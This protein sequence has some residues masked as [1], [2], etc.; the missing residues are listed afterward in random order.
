MGRLIALSGLLLLSGCQQE[1]ADQIAPPATEYEGRTLSQW[2]TQLAESETAE[3][4]VEAAGVLGEMGPAG[5]PALLEALRD[6]SEFVRAASALALADIGPE[7]EVAIPAIR[8]TLVD[9]SNRVRS[10]GQSALGRLQAAYRIAPPDLLAVDLVSEPPPG[11]QSIAGE[12]LV[13]PDGTVTLGQFGSVRV[14]SMTI[15]Q[16]KQS[17][18]RHLSAFFESPTVAV[19][20]RSFNS[21]VFYVVFESDELGDTVYRFPFTGTETLLDVIAYAQA[22]SLEEMNIWVAAPSPF[23]PSQGVILPWDGIAGE[24]NFQIYPGD[25]VVVSRQAYPKNEQREAKPATDDGEA[26]SRELSMQCL[27]AYRISPPDILSIDLVSE[28][29]VG[30]HLA[31][32]YLVNPDGTVTLDQYGG[33]KVASLTVAEAKQAIE[34]HLSKQFDSPIVS[35]SVRAYNSLVYY[36]VVEGDGPQ[37]S[38]YR[39]PVTGSD[40]VL[41]AIAHSQIPVFGETVQVIRSGNEILTAN[42]R[43]ITRLAATATNCQLLPDDRVVIKADG[44]TQ[45]AAPP[46]VPV[47]E[48]EEIP[49][50]PGFIVMARPDIATLMEAMPDESTPLE[51]RAALAGGDDDSRRASSEECI[52]L[53][54]L[55][56]GAE[57]EIGGQKLP[58]ASRIS[59]GPLEPDRVYIRSLEVDFDDGGRTE[60]KLFLQA[61]EVLNVPIRPPNAEN[62][63]LVLQSGH[64]DAVWSVTFSPDGKY[65]FTSSTSQGPIIWETATGRQVRSFESYKPTF[66]VVCN[67]SGDSFLANHA[68][69]AIL[70]DFITWEEK[71][72]WPLTWDYLMRP[73]SLAFSHD[74][75]QAIAA[76]GNFTLELDFADGVTD[77][78]FHED[79]SEV[80]CVAFS[81][82]GRQIFVG[83]KD[84][85]YL[86]DYFKTP[87]GG[88]VAMRA[89]SVG[90]TSRCAAFSPEGDVIVAESGKGTVGLWSADTGQ[91][92]R[93]L[94]GHTD[95]VSSVVFSPD[96]QKVLTGSSDKT[97]VVWEAATGRQLVVIDGHT[98]L[99]NS[100]A[101]SPDGRHV[102]TGSADNTAVL[103]DASS[104]ESVRDFSGRSERVEEIAF[105]TDGRRL[106]VSLHSN[107]ILWD[108]A[109][110]GSYQSFPAVSTTCPATMSPEGRKILT[111]SESGV[112][113]RDIDS[114]KQIASIAEDVDCARFS[115]DGRMLLTSQWAGEIRLWDA[116]TGAKLR[117]FVGQEGFVSSIA[118]SPNGK[119]V[120]TGSYLKEVIRWD[121]TTGEKLW[122]QPHGV[123]SVAFSPD[124]SKFATAFDVG[125][126]I[127][128]VWDAAT[129]EPLRTL[130]G[131]ELYGSHLAFTPDGR[132]LL[133]SE[134]YYAVLH[135]IAL[136]SPLRTFKGHTNWLLDACF[137]P[138]GKFLCTGSVDGTMRL[139]DVATGDEILRLISD[140]GEDWIAVTPEGLF[141]GSRQGRESVF[142]RAEEGLRVTPVDC[143]F[144][145]FYYPG[146]M[147]EIWR[148]QRPMPAKSL[149]GSPAP[150][151]QILLRDT[152]KR[153]DGRV[154]IDVVLTDQGGGIQDPWLFHNGSRAGRPLKV[155]KDDKTFRCEFDVSMVEGENRISVHSASRDGSWE[156]E[157]AVLTLD[158]D[159]SLPEPDLY[160]MAIGVDEFQSGDNL[161]G[162][163][164]GAKSI[165][166]LFQKHHASQYR[167]VRVGGLYGE[168]ATRQRILDYLQVLAEKAQPQDTIVV[169]LASHGLTIGQRYYLFPQDYQKSEGQTVN[170]AVWLWGMPID[171]LGNALSQVP[172]LKRV[173]IFD[174]CQSGG[175]VSSERSPFEFRGAVERFS[176]SQGIFCLAASSEYA[177][178]YEHPQTA[179]LGI[180]T[181]T[182]LAGMGAIEDENGLLGGDRLTGDGPDGEVDV[183]DWFRFADRHIPR[184]YEKLTSRKGHHV[185]M[186]GQE[187]SFAI[188]RL[189]P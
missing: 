154:T 48:H 114:G 97:A 100:V 65:V 4:R 181:F 91:Q 158:F 95:W 153:D 150:E 93:S 131:D 54:G 178:A 72:S 89:W 161:K 32:E 102:L 7:A 103:W 112:V 98:D 60:R 128:V 9:Q 175:A 144:R 25:R 85:G 45:V 21:Q 75:R 17:I 52:L 82:N 92:I 27:P 90:S 24:N 151:V 116:I 23:N 58:S 123:R 12:H 140:K 15:A 96:G 62:P 115:P 125:K 77:P 68:G 164:R 1:A 6:E 168:K 79:E 49:E 83:T 35:V 86:C 104:G 176:R 16:A 139:W 11:M 101:F 22:G 120:I 145:D 165:V 55:P 88:A 47:P 184:L 59:I 108:F 110:G 28:P 170:Q 19:S 18:E 51:A 113:I 2:A 30:T 14:A 10:A 177:Y 167:N 105:S 186:R 46:H 29:P 130:D 141:D 136:G 64:T 3:S 143:A 127:V 124:G 147:S 106:F 31:G 133:L 80:M 26:I 63:N 118:F 182:L 56:P 172:A 171:E 78:I 163:V 173:L 94:E 187:P 121:V 188:L 8:E 149:A 157:P 129:N 119:S 146:L 66:S 117:E 53:L 135:E 69:I 183:M 74:G 142:F 159:G 42:W 81:P 189:A 155:R 61:G 156:C 169:Y 71:E 43:A 37:D 84:N 122:S 132:Q 174:T 166:D 70:Y 109:R 36:V 44:P 160:V 152:P 185:E 148:G 107:G 138:D 39:F 180:L 13:N 73:Q 38:A 137:S 179:D 40:T 99:V 5:I 111:R 76:S 126:R 162:C 34:E 87:D 41:D 50:E 57:A 67:P 33:V 20:V 134:S